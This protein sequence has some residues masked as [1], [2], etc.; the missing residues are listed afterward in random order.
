MTSLRGVF[1]PVHGELHFLS[2]NKPYIFQSVHSSALHCWQTSHSGKFALSLSYCMENWRERCWTSNYI[3]QCPLTN[4]LDIIQ[5]C[6]NSSH[7]FPYNTLFLLLHLTLCKMTN[8]GI[9]T[10]SDTYN[11]RVNYHLALS[12]PTQ[13]RCP[14][15]TAILFLASPKPCLCFLQTSL[16]L[17]TLLTPKNR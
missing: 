10:I 15:S 6:H 3:F 16:L 7:T 4:Y 12:S 11:L 8:E 1:N 14:N 17:R 9:F 13:L 2:L 5:Y